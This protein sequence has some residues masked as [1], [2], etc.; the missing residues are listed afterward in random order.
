MTPFYRLEAHGLKSHIMDWI[1]NISGQVGPGDRII[2][3]LIGH[4]NKRDGAVTL[5]PQ[6]AKPEFL[7]KAKMIAALSVLPPNVRLLIVNEA[8]YSGTWATIA[9]EVGAQRDVLV[10]T[11]A[12]V[13]EQSWS[14]TS[15]SGRNRCSLFGAAF[16]EELTTHPEG[17]VS[18]HRSRIVDEMLHVGPDQKT[19]TPLMIPS[20]RALLSHNIS[21]FILSPRIATAITNVA[22]AQDRHEALLQSRTSFRTFW[23]RL[24]RRMSPEREPA[25]AFA[26]DSPVRDSTGIDMKA[27]VIENYL[28]DLGPL[29]SALD[30]CTL[31]TAGQFALEGRGSPEFQDQVIATI[32]WQAAQMQ[33]VGRLLE[34]LAKEGLITDVVDEEIAD[35]A[36]ADHQEDI[37]VPVPPTEGHVGVHFNDAQSWLIG[38]VAYNWL[39][40]PDT[41]DLDRVANE[42]RV[43]LA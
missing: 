4:G 5:Y 35:Q 11:A 8:C 38:I 22:S 41:F 13:G 3:V 15:G 2:I 33:R 32:A 30:Y 20:V 28:K 37:V 23:R 34:H 27:I 12:T 24:R 39:M 29:K 43:F 14:Y 42:V 26:G 10:E 6:H 31:A 17:R 16:V 1:R 19:S 7:S 36:L 40:Y 9:P 25:Q 18:Q 21:H